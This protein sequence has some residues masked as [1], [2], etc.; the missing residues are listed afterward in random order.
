MRTLLFILFSVTAYAQNDLYLHYS[1]YHRIGING[2]VK[3]ITEYE[4]IKL[5]YDKNAPY[6][7]SGELRYLKK[8]WFDKDGYLTKDST[9]TIVSHKGY[10]FNSYQE[11]SYSEKNNTITLIK[12]GVINDSIYSIDTSYIICKKHN[13]STLV[14]Q[15]Y[16][17]PVTPDFEPAPPN[18]PFSDLTLTYN[19][20]HLAL[21]H[22]VTYHHK[23]IILEE[24]LYH[25]DKD[26]NVIDSKKLLEK[27]KGKQVRTIVLDKD[28][29]GNP[30]KK[31]IL[32][33]KKAIS[34][35][36]YEIEYYE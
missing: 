16:N 35:T 5:D 33:N 15:E 21:S 3:T 11:Y 27:K 23:G 25:Y 31:I 14:Y 7:V 17:Y 29:V 30:T 1:N 36:R 32:K 6:N 20:K 10:T 8:K 19:T 22:K 34:I 12:L 4:Y 13:D 28:A 26:G 2:A 18:M 9:Y 24:Y